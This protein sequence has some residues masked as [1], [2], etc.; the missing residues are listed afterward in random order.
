[1][2]V[3]DLCNRFVHEH[4]VTNRISIKIK[5]KNKIQVPAVVEAKD[6]LKFKKNIKNI[7]LK[8]ALCN[9]CFSF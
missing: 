5:H 6:K 1:M 9:Y 7:K 3:V 8:K 4:K 2:C